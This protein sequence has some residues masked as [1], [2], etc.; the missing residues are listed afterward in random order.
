MEASGHGTI[1]AMEALRD[2]LTLR[3]ELVQISTPTYIFHGQKDEICPFDF[4][5]ELTGGI[6]NST[7]IPFE[8]SGHGLMFDEKEKF[9]QELLRVLQS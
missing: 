6:V 9:N 3:A 1:Q 4:T 2:E 7:I 5:A 8:N